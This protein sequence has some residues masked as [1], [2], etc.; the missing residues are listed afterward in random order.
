MLLHFEALTKRPKEKQVCKDRPSFPHQCCLK[1]HLLLLSQPS[2]CPPCLPPHDPHQALLMP[3]LFMSLINLSP[4]A[5]TY[6]MT[7]REVSY[8]ECLR[9]PPCL[10]PFQALKLSSPSALLILPTSLLIQSYSTSR[11]SPL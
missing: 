11:A 6:I 5:K 7:G 1:V 3:A 9:S 8:C 4:L 10:F 2:L